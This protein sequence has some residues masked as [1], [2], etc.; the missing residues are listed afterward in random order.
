MKKMIKIIGLSLL[1]CATANSAELLSVK[2]VMIG[3]KEVSLPTV[4]RSKGV[5]QTEICVSYIKSV[6]NTKPTSSQNEMGRFDYETDEYC[7]KPVLISVGLG[8]KATIPEGLD[9]MEWMPTSD[10]KAGIHL[11]SISK[12][13][14]SKDK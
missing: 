13:Y 4:L 5:T 10:G 14:S 1:F 7:G 2:K 8:A 9:S 6:T 3:D 12:T 11:L